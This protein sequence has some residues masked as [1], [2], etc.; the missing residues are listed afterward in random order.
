[1]TKEPRQLEITTAKLCSVLCEPFCPQLKFRE[2]YGGPKQAFLTMEDFTLAMERTPKDVVIVFAG[3]SEPFMNPRGMD[4]V[5]LALDQGREVEL[6]STLVGLRASEVGRLT[7]RLSRFVWHVPDNQGIA[8][9]PLTDSYWATVRE[10]L[11]RW[12]INGYSRMDGIFKSN[13]RAGNCSDAKPRHIKGIFFCRKLG[14]PQFVMLPDMRVLLCCMDWSIRNVVGS[15]R[16][17][18]Y[19]QIAAD[20]PYRRLMAERFKMDGPHEPGDCRACTVPRTL[21]NEAMYQAYKWGQ[22]RFGSSQGAP[23]AGGGHGLE[24]AGKETAKDLELEPA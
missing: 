12:D 4:M 15:L 5:E 1:M 23:A 17:K 2:A 6:F 3:H 14:T 13:E 20:E 24:S 18:T 9:I 22:R 8:H 16:E 10:V 11:A 19:N 21:K 7:G